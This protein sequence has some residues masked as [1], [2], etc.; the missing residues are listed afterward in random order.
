MCSTLLACGFC[1]APT[2]TSFLTLFGSTCK[3][4]NC[5]ILSHVCLCK[6]KGRSCSC[7]PQECTTR[8]LYFSWVYM[9]KQILSVCT[10]H[11]RT[12]IP[13]F[14]QCQGNVNE[15]SLRW[16]FLYMFEHRT[17]CSAEQHGTVHRWCAWLQKTSCA[18]CHINVW[19]SQ[20]VHILVCH[21]FHP[22]MVFVNST[23]RRS[24][25]QLCCYV[26]TAGT[27]CCT[28][29][30]CRSTCV[31][32]AWLG[33]CFCGT[34]SHHQHRHKVVV[35]QLSCTKLQ[36]L[37]FLFGVF[38]L[39]CKIFPFLAQL[40]LLLCQFFQPSRN[41]IR[42][43]WVHNC[44]FSSSNGWFCVSGGLVHGYDLQGLYRGR[45]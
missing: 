5:N 21:A 1:M 32:G 28:C 14:E 24:H 29:T 38:D 40:Q 7:I 41:W 34:F 19:Q 11:A 37:H 27:G 9:W 23:F 2:C 44:C 3:L 12:F 33:F 26:S 17:W 45:G 15:W 6:S 43:Q 22:D 4:H 20:H 16:S 25:V 18:F 13:D 36:S 8:T 42:R 10:S 39:P 35:C 30:W 31:A